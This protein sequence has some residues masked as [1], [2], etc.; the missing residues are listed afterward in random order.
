MIILVLNVVL[1]A[2]L[3]IGLVAPLLWAIRPEQWAIRTGQRDRPVVTARPR[4]ARCPAAYGS[5]RSQAS[6][7]KPVIS[8]R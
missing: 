1:C 5:A 7:S 6:H 2:V 4:L 8:A 3:L